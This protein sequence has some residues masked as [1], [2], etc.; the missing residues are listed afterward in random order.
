[1]VTA[2]TVRQGTPGTAM[3]NLV[4]YLVWRLRRTRKRSDFMHPYKSLRRIVDKDLGTIPGD[5]ADMAPLR[6]GR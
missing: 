5:S 2:K 3:K 6:K 1:M 4:D